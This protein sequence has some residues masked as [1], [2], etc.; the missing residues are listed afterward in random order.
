[1]SFTRDEVILALDLYYSMPNGKVSKDSPEMQELSAL[2]NRLPIHPLEGRRSDFRPASGI[3]QQLRLFR[4]SFR[5]RVKSP[6]LGKLFLEIAGEFEGRHDELYRIAEAIRRNESDFSS[7]FGSQAEDIGFPEGVLLGHLHRCI[8]RRDGAA[9]PSD[10]TCAVCKLEPKFYYSGDVPILE[11][12]LLVDPLIMSAS[13]KYGE[14]D[15]ICVCPTCHA[16]LHRYRPWRGTEI[17][18]TDVLS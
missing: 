17:S 16:A 6:D 11:Q 18:V 7:L 8:E 2:L 5:D 4:N 14:R 1:M 12:H 10:N 3:T 9:L 13:R 15:F